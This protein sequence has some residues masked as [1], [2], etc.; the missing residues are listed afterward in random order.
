MKTKHFIIICSFFRYEST[1]ISPIRHDIGTLTQA[2]G[3]RLGA[4]LDGL[5]TPSLLGIYGTAPYLHDGSAQSL[6][7]AVLKHSSTELLDEETKSLLLSFL[8]SL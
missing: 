1:D 6:E 3:M 2:S 7:E 5:D 8:L 4:P